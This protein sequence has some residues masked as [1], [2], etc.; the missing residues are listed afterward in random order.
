MDGIGLST[1][2]IETTAT[3]DTGKA[4]VTAADHGEPGFTINRPAAFDALVSDSDVM[5]RIE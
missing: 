1:A 4:N 3:S 5:R 2:F